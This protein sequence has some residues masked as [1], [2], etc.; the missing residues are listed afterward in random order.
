[1]FHDQGQIAMKLT[2]F[3]RGVTVQGGL[4][5]PITTPAHGTACDIVGRGV[6]NPQAMKN[7]SANVAAQLSRKQAEIDME[8]TGSFA[9]MPAASVSGFYFSHPDSTYFNVGKIGTDQL[10]DQARRRGMDKAE[11]ER[12]LAPNL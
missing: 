7:G 11:L 8:L 9:M 2:G 12:W 5:I 4:P 1:M 3:E 10:E 6:A